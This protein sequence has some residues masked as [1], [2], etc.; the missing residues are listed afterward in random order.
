MSLRPYQQTAVDEIR[1]FYRRGIK[2]V[3][4]HMPTGS[5][6]TVIFSFILKSLAERGK[7][8]LMVVHGRQL[9]DQAA[10]RDTAL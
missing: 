8:A 10:A 9:V 7:T 4:L 5:G 3:L 2:R 6:K 1:D